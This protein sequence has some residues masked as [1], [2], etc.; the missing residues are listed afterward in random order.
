MSMDCIVIPTAGRMIKS[1]TAENS[2]PRKRILIFLALAK[3]TQ[4]ITTQGF[5]KR[6]IFL[7]PINSQK[8]P[9][10]GVKIIP[11]NVC[12]D[13]NHEPISSSREMSSIV[14]LSFSN[15]E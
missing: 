4:P 5:E 8:Y 1:E 9:P 11:V 14:I 3:M 12:I 7:L 13:A 10:N 2:L 15:R 6:I